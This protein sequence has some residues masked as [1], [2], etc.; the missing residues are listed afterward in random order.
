MKNNENSTDKSRIEISNNGEEPTPPT[1]TRPADSLNPYEPEDLCID[2]NAIHAAGAVSR[3]ITEIPMRKPRKHEFFRTDPDEEHWRPVALIEFEQVWYLVHPRI[4]PHLD[5]DDICYAYLCLA[6][7]KSGE[8]FY[9]PLKISNKGRANLWNDSALG[10]AK[11][12]T[13]KWVKMRSRREDGKGG[14]GFYQE[15]IP[16]ANFGDPKWPELTQK[17]LYAIAFKGDRIIDRVD[18]L[19]IQKLTGQVK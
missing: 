3:P 5:P 4:V 11:E 14:S 13:T 15:E 10:I 1:E 12:A 8:L 16:I 7:S 18:H 17:Q 6:I 2:L 9:W 19:V